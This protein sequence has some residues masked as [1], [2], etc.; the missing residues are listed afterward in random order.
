MHRDGKPALQWEIGASLTEG[1]GDRE[2]GGRAVGQQGGEAREQGPRGVPI[3]EP[4]RGGRT[5]AHPNVGE[6]TVSGEQPLEPTPG[7]SVCRQRRARDAALPIPA[8]DPP[9]PGCVIAF[10]PIIFLFFFCLLIAKQ[11]TSRKHGRA[12]GVN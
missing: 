5:V 9:C 12:V 4:E 10:G 2:R 11:R 3:V 7:W 1:V 6:P 8:T